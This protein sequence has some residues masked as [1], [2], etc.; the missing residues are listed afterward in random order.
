MASKVEIAIV[1]LDLASNVIGTITNKLGKLGASLRSLIGGAAKAGFAALAAGITGAAIAITGFIKAAAGAELVRA[2]F[3]ALF[4]ASAVGQYTEQVMQT[5]K[6]IETFVNRLGRTKTV[7][8]YV[9][10]L[11]TVTRGLDAAFKDV[12]ISTASALSEVTRFNKETVLGAA[13]TIALYEHIGQDIF[14][15]VMDLALDVAE[16]LSVDAAQGAETLARGLNDIAGGSLSVLKTAGLLTQA[17]IDAAQ[18]MANMGKEAEAQAYILG[19]LDEKIGDVAETVGET[20]AGQWAILGNNINDLKIEIGDLFKDALKPLLTTF[21][22]LVTKYGPAVVAWFETKI[23]P[24]VEKLVGVLK[25]LFTGKINISEA[26]SKMFAIGKDA[27]NNILQPL[28]DNLKNVDWTEVGADIGEKIKGALDAVDWN[29]VGKAV[30][31]GLK[32]VKDI[33]M[34]MDWK[35]IAAGI[36][37]AFLEIGTGLAGSDPEEFKANWT[38]AFNGIKA[39]FYN[40]GADIGRAVVSIRN[41]ISRFMAIGKDIVTGLQ[42][43][44]Q[45][46][47]VSFTTWFT[48]QI[49]ALIDSVLSALGIRSPST[50]FANIGKQMM[51]GLAV[52]IG[53]GVQI[54]VRAMQAVVPQ[55][56]A[57]VNGQSS[58]AQNHYYYGARIMLEQGNEGAIL[59]R[60]TV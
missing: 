21:N 49:Q 22:D 31:E 8:S 9:D 23:I 50:V 36:G 56:T 19:I 11:V 54:P 4:D 6:H 33:A 32:I 26:I 16:A 59:A 30:L 20:W 40:F 15:Q 43:G 2:K 39:L 42:T 48:A 41:Q 25:D 29:A 18:S 3:N 12:V 44:I 53:D 1:A 46:A 34:G 5:T 14:P 27:L 55:M 28:K 37:N 13:T 45:L 7:V 58:G 51:A 57:A 35:G 52:G 38:N 17:E 60:L 24:A 47:W 10:E